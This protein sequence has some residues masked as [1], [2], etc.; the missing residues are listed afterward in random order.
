MLLQG[1]GF[2][3]K[4]G[5]KHSI[6]NLLIRLA[7][8]NKWKKRKSQLALKYFNKYFSSKIVLNNWSKV[9]NDLSLRNI[10]Y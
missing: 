5:D 8:N 2:Y 9:I 4:F 6:A 1:Y 3:A 10:N 7:N